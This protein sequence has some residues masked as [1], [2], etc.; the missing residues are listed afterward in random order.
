M[1]GSWKASILV[2]E[3]SESYETLRPQ[4]ILLSM[5]KFKNTVCLQGKFSE[6]FKGTS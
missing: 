5:E 3:K 4:Y 1:L 2:A 6:H